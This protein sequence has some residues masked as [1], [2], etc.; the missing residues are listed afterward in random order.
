MAWLVDLPTQVRRILGWRN[1]GTGN[2]QGVAQGNVL[3]QYL[4]FAQTVSPGMV[5]R[6]RYV[7]TSCEVQDESA[8]LDT[9]G[10]VL[11]KWNNDGTIDPTA[12]ATEVTDF[13]AVVIHGL[14]RVLLDEDVVGGEWAF[15]TD[16]PGAARG[17][18]DPD[19][20][21]FGLFLGDGSAGGYAMVKVGHPGGGGGGGGGFTNGQVEAHFSP[22]VGGQ[23]VYS[24][25]PYDGTITGWAMMGDDPSG[26][27]EVDVWLA[28]GALPTSAD[29]IV[30]SAPPELTSDDYA[31]STTLTGWSTSVTEGQVIAFELGSLSIHQQVSVALSITRSS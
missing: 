3:K 8:A 14:C 23:V 17:E 20:G 21:A 25:V 11:G 5:V 31:A 1:G 16:T 4:R 18:T 22:A 26:D 13:V 28:T 29:S 12:D 27:A 10:V 6:T 9:I 19:V 24:R 2:N 30:A 7:P 15:P